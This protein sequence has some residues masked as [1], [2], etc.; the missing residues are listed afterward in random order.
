MGKETR[1][2]TPQ[3]YMRGK[4]QPLASVEAKYKSSKGG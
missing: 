2:T 3:S 4:E 1:K